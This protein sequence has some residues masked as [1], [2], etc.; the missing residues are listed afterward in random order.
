MFIQ[1]YRKKIISILLFIIIAMMSDSVYAETFNITAEYI[2]SSYGHQGSYFINKTPC[3][4]ERPYGLDFCDPEKPLESATIIQFLVDVFRSR[5][6]SKKSKSNYLSYYQTSG[7]KKII[8]TNDKDGTVYELKM[9]PTHIGVE[10][11]KMDL[12]G[13]HPR[14]MSRINGDCIFFDRKSMGNTS[15]F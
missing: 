12:S 13:D 7:P 4:M 1:Y 5:I 15:I 14:P 2:P 11:E 10:T 3:R 8:V 9:I 6:S